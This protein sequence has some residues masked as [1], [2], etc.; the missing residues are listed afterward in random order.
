VSEQDTSRVPPAVKRRRRPR[1]GRSQVHAFIADDV[2]RRFKAYCARRGLSDCSVIEEALK[3]HLDQTTDAALIMRRL[4]RTGRRIDK[5][6]AD[7]ELLTEF[8]SLWVR[9]WFAHT[10]QI[11]DAQKG[12]AQSSAAKRYE[13][14]LAYLSKRLS[15]SQRLA[16][17]LLGEEALVD[18][19]EPPSPP[20]RSEA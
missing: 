2:Y 18:S 9:L 20:S 15:G 13:Q 6:R 14:F 10:P 3:Q 11:A 7:L 17:E 12:A 5:I 4:D 8:V 19:P 1:R 16:I